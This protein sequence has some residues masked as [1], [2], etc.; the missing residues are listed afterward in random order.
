[1]TRADKESTPTR[2]W[3]RRVGVDSMS[4]L[5]VMPSGLSVKLEKCSVK[6]F[7]TLQD[8]AGRSSGK[9]RPFV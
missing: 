1:M 8:N 9:L 4:T 7:K 3:R 5:T 6:A 2:R